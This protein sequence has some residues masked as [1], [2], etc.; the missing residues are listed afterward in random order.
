[1]RIISSIA[2]LLL[3]GF[4]FLGFVFSTGA[5]PAHAENNNFTPD[6][7]REIERILEDY[8]LANPEIVKQ[9]IEVLQAKDE[10]AKVAKRAELLESRRDEIFADP[11]APFAGNPNGDVVIVE[12][13]DYKCPY[14]KSVAPAL[15]DLLGSDPNLKLVFKEFPILG[16]G[17]VLAARA[18]LA[19]GKQGK[20]QEFHEALMQYKGAFDPGSVKEIATGLGLDVP[21][22][23][24]DLQSAE[25]RDMLEANH[26][27]AIDLAIGSTPT[28]IIGKEVIP[29]AIPLEELRALVAK[30]RS[31]S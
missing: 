2:G 19:A 9:A 12:F 24:A 27:L 26:S 6:E 5:P 8:L 11:N 7:A 30:A 31:E 20:Y 18:A 4:L 14:C 25:V 15:F 16:E 17:S 10:A 1:M 3:L 13:F 28:F 21:R 29:G 22:L 23:I